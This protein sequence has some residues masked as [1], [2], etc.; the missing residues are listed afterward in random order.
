MNV[1]FGRCFCALLLLALLHGCAASRNVAADPP[2]LFPAAR[3]VEFVGIE[4]RYA[5]YIV[6]GEISA[7]D[8]LGNLP[9]ASGPMQID[10][11]AVEEIGMI[12]RHAN[13][14][15]SG[16]WHSY[17]FT[18]TDEV[19]PITQPDYF[20]FEK[21]MLGGFVR[22]RVRLKEKPQNGILTMSALHRGEVLLTT[23]FAFVNCE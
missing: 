15:G 20:S 13:W 3:Y 12:V 23:Q 6:A 21:L 19:E 5:E 4:G 1:V 7:R 17:K 18:L 11:S 10:C 14:R 8:G 22:G 9:M 16:Y 2:A